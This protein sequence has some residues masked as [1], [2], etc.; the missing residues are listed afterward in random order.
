MAQI[1][2]NP[3]TTTTTGTGATAATTT[4]SSATTRS[5]TGSAT[6]TTGT[7]TTAGATTPQTLLA[8][9]EQG[10]ASQGT[11]TQ[12][13]AAQTAEGQ[14]AQAAGGS[15][16][17]N[18]APSNGVP[19]S[20]PPP[21]P[22]P[23][24]VVLASGR[25]VSFTADAA[26]AYSSGATLSQ[27]GPQL[28]ASPQV[29]AAAGTLIQAA[30]TGGM[31]QAVTVLATGGL[32]L[33]EQ[34]AVLASVPVTTLIG[35]LT[36]SSDPVAVRVGGI[37]QNSAAG[38]PGGYAQ[39]RAAAAQANLPPQV[40]RTYLA[41]VQRVEREQRT[42]AFSGALRQLVANPSAADMFGRPAATSSP[43][44]LQQARGGRTRGGTMT[45]RGIVA[46][47]A[48]LAE[49]RVNGRWVFIDE[50]GQFR[51]SIPV[52]PGAKEATLTMTDEAGKT[53]EQRI[54][55]DSATAAP[56]PAAPPKP[57]KIALMIAVDSYRDGAIPALATPDADIKAVGKALN[58]HLGYETR[59][60]RN[61]TKA[62][63]GE[64][65]RKLGREV[66][67]QD[68]VMVYY[69]GHGYELAETGTGYWLPA[70]A[71]T[72]SA[73]NWVSNND[74]G[75]FLSR[76]PAKHVMVVSDSC[77]SGA[78]TKEQKV[79]ASRLANETEIRQRRSVMALSSGGDEPVA[80]GEVNS[81]FA[82]ALKTR[83]LGLPKDSSGYALYQEVRQ[84]VTSEAPQTP[85][86]GVIR[87]AGYDEGGDFLLDL[88]DRAM[89]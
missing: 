39:V 7:G 5:S 53:T 51:T 57:R 77:Y 82:V 89:N 47:S 36:A 20:P 41:M 2:A 11:A 59:V 29:Q 22:G 79:D 76:M 30:G 9:L 44:S 6:G 80:D 58:D 42:Q 52:E 87:T 69:A 84:D 45:L 78:F 56:D 25:S 88:P 15:S 67:E 55:I 86:Y 60:L 70:D 38:Q 8:T 33:P 19:A 31:V 71:E 50:Q 18:S 65:L 61:P 13:A 1:A 16:A 85:Q 43:P 54:A 72:T 73:R 75:R 74:I 81:P 32:S 66:G 46:D 83:V 34:R 26:A 64:A 14:G 28:L 21:P 68:Q 63:I 12:T 35:G 49:A 23:A 37:L 62:Q 17:S 24:T 27:P 3:A 48:N 10:A 4:G 40:A